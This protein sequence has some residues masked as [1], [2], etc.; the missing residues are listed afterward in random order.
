MGTRHLIAVMKDGEYKIAQYG[1][2]DGYPDGQG[3]DCLHFLQY[4]DL[5]V[6]AKKLELLEWWTNEQMRENTGMDDWKEL[7]PQFSRDTGAKILQFVMSNDQPMGM[8]NM[9]DFA[10]DSLFCEWAYVIDL[11]QHTF[12]VYEGY[13]KSPL[14]DKDERFYNAPQYNPEYYPVHLLAKFDIR[15]TIPDD[16]T[17]IAACTTEE[18]ASED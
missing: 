5:T 8:Y 6:F 16:E 7:F 12:E 10:G 1:Q 2:W 3:L 14:V 9:I 18:E 15:N 11:D 17:F 13:N 4:A